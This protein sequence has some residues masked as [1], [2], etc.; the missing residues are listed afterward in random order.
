[1]RYAG[2]IYLIG[3]VATVSI[4]VYGSYESGGFHR[5]HTLRD[6]MTITAFYA[7]T[8]ALW[9]TIIVIF[10]LKYF[11]ALPQIWDI[12]LEKFALLVVLLVTMGM[13]IW[14]NFR[15]LRRAREAGHSYW[16]INPMSALAGLRGKEP[17]IFVI[18]VLV[19]FG[20]VMSLI[21]LEAGR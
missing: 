9:P 3:A 2:F 15:I 14:A 7:A 13:A 1:M 16:L 6:L 20:S 5:E 8:A 4:L 19:G 12:T 11:G 21:A 17:L 10:P 18:A